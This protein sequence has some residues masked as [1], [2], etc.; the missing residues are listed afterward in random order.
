MINELE[1]AYWVPSLTPF[2][3]KSEWATAVIRLYLSRSEDLVLSLILLV[4][5]VAFSRHMSGKPESTV[6]GVMPHR[7][8]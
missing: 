1:P 2:R 4:T 5:L 8:Q 6:D 7:L 3:P